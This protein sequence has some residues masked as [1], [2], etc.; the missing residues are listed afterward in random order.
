M[1]ARS[2]GIRPLTAGMKSWLWCGA[3]AWGGAAV[4]ACGGAGSDARGLDSGSDAAPAAGGNGAG[5]SGGV[6]GELAF[7]AALGGSS[8]NAGVAGASSGGLGGREPSTFDAGSTGGDY[9]V[10]I[11]SGDHQMVPE[12][13]P[14]G[15]PMVVEARANGAPAPGLTLSWKISD[16]W[17]NIGKLETVTDASGRSENTFIGNYVPAN[18]SFTRQKVSVSAGAS[19]ANGAN[20]ATFALTT[21]DT[22]VNAPTMPLS[23]LE[24]PLD[25]NLGS[26]KSGSKLAGVIQVRVVNQAGPFVGSPLSDIGVVLVGPPGLSCQGGMVLTDDKGLATCDLVVGTPSGAQSFSVKVGGASVLGGLVLDVTP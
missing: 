15:E 25:K 14:A 3:L 20:S 5:S 17:G 23:V 12:M 8:G 19:G 16:G 10:S 4:V 22:G 13:Y 11:V 1:S 18:V 9:V 26:A 7:D 21:C 6:G 24:A 2:L